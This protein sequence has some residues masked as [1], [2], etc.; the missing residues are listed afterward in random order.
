MRARQP[1][2]AGA[3][4]VGGPMAVFFAIDAEGSP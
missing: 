2:F 3:I 1:G 4:I